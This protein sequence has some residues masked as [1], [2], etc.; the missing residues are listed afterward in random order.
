[1]KIPEPII[2]PATSMVE[3]SNPSPRTNLFSLGGDDSGM[4]LRREMRWPNESKDGSGKNARPHK[5][6]LRIAVAAD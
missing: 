5:D 1:M 2:E 6:P 4:V 3:S